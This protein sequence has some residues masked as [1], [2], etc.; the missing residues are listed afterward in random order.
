MRVNFGRVMSRLRPN[1]EGRASRSSGAPRYSGVPAAASVDGEDSPARGSVMTDDASVETLDDMLYDETNP[2]RVRETASELAHNIV[3]LPDLPLGVVIVYA[4][5]V[6]A[7]A[8]VAIWILRDASANSGFGDSCDTPLPLWITVFVGRHVLKVLMV[9]A[10]LWLSRRSGH[11]SAFARV[12]S[13]IIT[14]NRLG[15]YLWLLGCYLLWVSNT[16]DKGVWNFAMVMCLMQ[17]VAVALPIALLFLVMCCLP[18]LLC[19]LPIMFPPDANQLATRDDMVRRIPKTEYHRLLEESGSRSPEGASDVPD[20]CP[21]CLSDFAE[22]DEV[23]TL[24]CNTRHIFHERCVTQWLAVSQLCP[25]CRAN[26]SDML[27]AEGR[28]SSPRDPELVGV[29]PVFRRSFATQ[30]GPKDYYQV[31]GVPHNASQ[32]D[33]K[34]AYRKLAMKWHPDRNPDNRS[35]AEAKFKDIGEAY[36]TLGDEGKRRQ[37]DA[38][39]GA[40]SS[41]GGSGGPGGPSGPHAGTSGPFPGGGFPGGGFPGGGFPGDG[42]PGGGGFPGGFTQ[43]NVHYRQ[44]SM[45]EAQE[46]FKR[47]MGMDLDDLLRTAMRDGFATTGGPSSTRTSSR[48]DSSGRSSSSS[49]RPGSAQHPFGDPRD[50]SGFGSLFGN[51]GGDFG[52]LFREPPRPNKRAMRRAPGFLRRLFAAAAALL[53]PSA[54][55]WATASKNEGP[56]V[57]HTSTKQEVVTKNGKKM[58]RTTTT[59]EHVDGTTSTQTKEE[60]IK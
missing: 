52:N 12:T 23:M 20:S 50:L 59:T 2:Y 25:I 30:S 40:S 36:Q 46:L 29:S 51:M 17:F 14:C 43:G 57:A 45:E 6:A 13:W 37:Y 22:N 21:I 4:M 15:Y 33:I 53:V 47:A 11:E 60:L 9:A 49:S 8:L 10:R 7:V 39:E 55:F 44:M 38:F 19:L 58:L 42:F 32:D 3:T 28:G 27:D 16:C 41:F 1:S 26:I 35:E 54:F 31:L 18:C 34:K 56:A 24:P 48:A 5:A